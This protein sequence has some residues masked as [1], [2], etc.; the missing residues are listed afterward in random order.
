MKKTDLIQL[1]IL[2]IA[3]LLGY[4]ALQTLPYM[5]WLLYHWLGEGLTLSGQ[6]PNTVINFLFFAFYI[7]GAIILIRKSKI[8]SQ[9]IADLA[10]FSSDINITV[11]KNDILYVTLIAMGTYIL[12][13]R[14][15][16]LLVNIYLYIREAN[17]PFV[18]DGPNF[19]LPGETI[20][21]FI[22][23]I[24]FAI[25]LIAYARPITQSLARRVEEPGETEEIG[26]KT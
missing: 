24:I 15:P 4:N 11:K 13:T 22:I 18:Y 10:S 3:L 1:V 6:F 26:P 8:L 20:A 14:L 19:T 2:V 23:A 21:E 17:K 25:I 16:K 7:I 5:I 12:L 9:K